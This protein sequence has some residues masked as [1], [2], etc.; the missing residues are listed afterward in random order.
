MSVP[1]KCYPR[2]LWLTILRN[3]SHTD[4]VTFSVK[5]YRWFCLSRF[6][7]TERAILSAM[8]GITGGWTD[9]LTTGS[10]CYSEKRSVDCG[11]DENKLTF[12]FPA[13]FYCVASLIL[14]ATESRRL[15]KDLTTRNWA[16]ISCFLPI[17]KVETKKVN[18]GFLGNFEEGNMESNFVSIVKL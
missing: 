11:S 9:Q 5:R 3:V 18:L 15:N 13:A 8:G 10:E 16:I 4:P 12:D 7:M 17:S 1:F 2:W 6:A 14:S